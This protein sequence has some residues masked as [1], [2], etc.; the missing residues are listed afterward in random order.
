MRILFK[1]NQYNQQRQFEKPRWIYPVKLAAYATYLRNEGHDVYWDWSDN[2]F[3]DLVITSESQIAVPFLKLPRPDREFTRA[4]DPKWMKNGNFKY[5]P[6]TYMQVANGCWHGKCTFCVEKDKPYE[7]RP[8][9]DCIEEIKEIKSQGY[10]EVFDDSG[11]FPTGEWFS[12]FCNAMQ[13]SGLN[14]QIKFGCNMRLTQLMEWK[15]DADWLKFYGFRMVL[16]GLESASDITL[17]II[18]KGIW[19]E[20]IIPTLKRVSQYLDIHGAFMF[21]YPFETDEDSIRTLK[22]AHYLLRKG[23]LKTAQAS[24]YTSG[25]NN[26]QES[27]RKYIKKIYDVK[28]SPEFWFNQLKDI[29]NTDDLKYLWKKI[30]AGVGR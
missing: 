20:K 26:S 18:N 9:E 25:E 28:Y 6:A 1:L 17:S 11:T 3:F 10:R 4:K 14:K 21:G 8:V 24:F 13:Q 16:V 15:Q 29:R 12:N 7:V 22:L 2:P 19:V 23:Y 30:K 5:L 27:Q